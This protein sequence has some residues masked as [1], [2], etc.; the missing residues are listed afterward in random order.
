MTQFDQNHMTKFT[1]KKLRLKTPL[2]GGIRFA[3]T[4]YALTDKM[5]A[6]QLVTEIKAVIMNRCDGCAVGSGAGAG[7]ARIKIANCMKRAELAG[8]VATAGAAKPALK[9][10]CERALLSK[11]VA[12][13]PH[14]EGRCISRVICLCTALKSRFHKFKHK[15][16]PKGLNKTEARD[17]RVGA[18]FARQRIASRAMTQLLYTLGGPSGSWTPGN[19]AY[20]TPHLLSVGVDPIRVALCRGGGGGVNNVF[21][22][23]I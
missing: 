4:Q 20:L 10:V 18:N 15:R 21:I 9:P 6:S 11:S 3:M 17:G 8:D 23:I 12:M 7:G 19:V 1:T 5:R 13:P 22:R 16:T 2:L 14:A